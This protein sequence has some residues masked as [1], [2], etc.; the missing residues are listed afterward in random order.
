MASWKSFKRKL[1]TAQQISLMDWLTLAEAWRALAGSYLAL[2]WINLETLT[3]STGSLPD[4]SADLPGEVPS[5]QRLGRLLGLASR[6]HFLPMTC[7]TRALALRHMLERRGIPARVQI[8]AARSSD[9]F[10]AHAWVEVRGRV[11]G[12]SGDVRERF[13]KFESAT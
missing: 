1:H 5:A 8:G 13:V 2:R 4:E 10:Q 9:R 7:L 12:E 6:C 3:A 11:I